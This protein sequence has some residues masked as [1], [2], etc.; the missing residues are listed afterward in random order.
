MFMEI[1]SLKIIDG[2]RERRDGD[3][4]HAKTARKLIPYQPAQMDEKRDSARRLVR[5]LPGSEISVFPLGRGAARL[6]L[7]PELF[8]HKVSGAQRRGEKLTR[9]F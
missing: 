5:R 3:I 7:F 8:F 6:F 1:I 9:S 2:H 4:H